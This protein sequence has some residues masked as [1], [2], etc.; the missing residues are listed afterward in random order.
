[1]RARVLALPRGG[2][3]LAC[4]RERPPDV[5]PPRASAQ[6]RAATVTAVHDCKLLAMDKAAFI[7]VMGPMHAILSRNETLYNKFESSMK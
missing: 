7:R 1:M 5:H 2:G 3:A 6:P 4:A